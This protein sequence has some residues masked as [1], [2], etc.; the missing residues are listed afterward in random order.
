VINNKYVSNIRQTL[1]ALLCAAGI[2]P[3]ALAQDVCG[4]PITLLA[5]Q[6]RMVGIPCNPGANNT[7]VD[8]FGPSLGPE[9]YNVTWIAWTRTYSASGADVYVKLVPASTVKAGDA[10]WIYST[11]AAT[12]QVGSAGRS[13][14]AGPYFDIPGP[15]S[16]I[17]SKRY[18]MFASPYSNAVS[19]ASL[20]FTGTYAGGGS[21]TDVT[22]TDARA[23]EKIL[24]NT[25]HFW[26]GN[27]YY[28]RNI[29]SAPQSVFAPHESGWLLISTEVNQL[30]SLTIR[31]PAP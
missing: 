23:K 3:G 29:A 15:P 19:G 9:N 27:T 21:F 6:W 25:V 16:T 30:T 28:T 7:I 13:A 20:L 31:V 26:N 24:D 17:G 5:E 4:A 18:F 22:A 12:L 14:T 2:A 11:T 8:V 1:L 10:L